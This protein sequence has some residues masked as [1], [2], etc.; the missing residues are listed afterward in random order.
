MSLKSVL[1]N[2]N[3][4]DRTVAFTCLQTAMIF[5]PNSPFPKGTQLLSLFHLRPPFL[6]RA[7]LLY[8]QTKCAL[9]TVS[10]CWTRREG[11]G[12]NHGVGLPRIQ[13]HAEVIII[14]V[15]FSLVYNILPYFI[16]FYCNKTQKK[17]DH[18][19]TPNKTYSMGPVL[20]RAQFS[21]RG[22]L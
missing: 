4:N 20:G 12:S 15:Q 3:V 1:S 19:K 11:L 2:V 5:T 22:V 14:K 9:P 21:A 7:T 13:R 10:P 8:H 6:G 16:I 18:D 17:R